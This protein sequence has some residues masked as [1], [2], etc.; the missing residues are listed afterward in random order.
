MSIE[1]A[2]VERLPPVLYRLTDAIPVKRATGVVWTL[3]F[4]P[5]HP[6][7]AR[8]TG[9]RVLVVTVTDSRHHALE[10]HGPSFTHQEILAM[11]HP[12]PASRRP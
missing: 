1:S 5:I 4:T 11:E 3:T 10:E 6:R 7:T 8:E 2:A 12:S 9:A